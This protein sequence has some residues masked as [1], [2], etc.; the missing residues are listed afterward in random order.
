MTMLMLEGK[1]I[2]IT[3]AAQG[4]GK[5]A[6]TIC[7]REGARV[8]IADLNGELG[9]SVATSIA[10]SGGQAIAIET[11]ASRREDVHHLVAKTVATFGSVD[12]LIC[13]GMRRIYRPAEEFT[14]EEWEV[15]VTQG[16]TGYFRCA[17]ESARQMLRQGSGAIVMVTSIA[18]QNAVAGGAA[19]CSVKAG[20][21][22][23]TRQL[24]VEWARRGIRTNSVAPGFT[25]TEG[26]MRVMSADEAE[27]TIPLGRPAHADEI[28][29]VCA[30]LLSDLASHVTA[31]EIVVDGGY[32]VGKSVQAGYSRRS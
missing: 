30:F 12:G 2:I 29:N 24:G 20:V 19:Y 21:A 8:I 15:V 18:S 25:A 32:S 16:L 6:A 14:D 7:A 5:A 26:A 13:A 27:A 9:R 4:I 23:L 31:Q 28:G 10:A 3:G 17:Q 11:D 1:S 22:G